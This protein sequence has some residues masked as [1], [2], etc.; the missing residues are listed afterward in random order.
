MIIFGVWGHRS[1]KVEIL[2]KKPHP[3]GFKPF[4][5]EIGW[6]LASSIVPEKI[7][8]KFVYFAYAP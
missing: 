4:C 2:L 5:T 7:V 8:T 1:V 6:G 3:G